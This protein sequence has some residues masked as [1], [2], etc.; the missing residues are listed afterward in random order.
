MGPGL[1]PSNLGRRRIVLPWSDVR[2]R[3]RGA[4]P[5]CVAVVG[6]EIV[7]AGAAPDCVAAVGRQI[8]AVGC[9]A[10]LCCRGGTT[11]CGGG[12]RRRVVLPWSDVRLWRRVLRRIL[13]PWWDVRVLLLHDEWRPQC[14]VG[15]KVIGPSALGGGRP[16][17]S[18][19]VFR[20]K[21]RFQ[22]MFPF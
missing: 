21:V 18:S 2:L 19:S 9:D 12:V 20:L 11:D 17:A 15:V 10:G 1:W 8:L 5:D 13:L 14:G 7:A 3:R 22:S 6:C 16:D 4:T